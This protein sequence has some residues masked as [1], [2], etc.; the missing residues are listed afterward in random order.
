MGG[1]SSEREVSLNSGANVMKALRDGGL[2]AFV[3]DFDGD[4]KRLILVLE[5][6][7][8][9]VVFNILHGRFGEDGYVQAVLDMVGMPYTH[10]GFLASAICMNKFYTN[11]ILASRGVRVPRNKVVSREDYEDGNTMPV[12]YVMK[13]IDG[14]SSIGVH[15]VKSGEPPLKEW[16][17]GSDSALVEEYVSGRELTVA[18]FKGEALGVTEI[19]P[20]EGFYD[21]NNKY[22]AG[23]ARHVL[24]ADIGGASA[25]AAK[26]IASKAYGI[27][28][29]S[30]LAR[31]D[32]IYDGRD[33]VFL[34]MNTQPG[35]T[36][37]SLAPEQAK[38]RGIPF[39]A[40][41]RIMV[42]DAL[43]RAAPISA[44]LSG[45]Q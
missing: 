40:L 30:G 22:T 2:D 41:V 9:D 44:A 4:I 37:L 33:M 18:V 28:G 19:I 39:E 6:R 13:P 38:A 43:A 45:K 15:I 24:P 31:A 1:I 8:P 11:A 5:S 7:K 25:A 17:Y 20:A 21:Y 12:P 10:S 14:G 3:H 34:E 16:P 23:G 35:M 42:E 26:E 36:E 27:L 29:C 32:F